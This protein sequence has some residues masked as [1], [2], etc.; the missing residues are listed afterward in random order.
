M[1]KNNQNQS[2]N[3]SEDKRRG[4]GRY[5]KAAIVCYRCNQ[6]GH[7]KQFCPGQKFIKD[8]SFILSQYL[9]K[10]IDTHC[11]LD[12]IF[13]KMRINSFDKL[14]KHFP[15]NFAGCISIYCDPAALSPSLS[16]YGEQLANDQVFGAFGIHPHNAKYYNESV[17]Q[18]ICEALTH[19]KAVA[20]GECGLDFHYNHSEKDIQLQVFEKQLI[21]AKELMKPIIIHAREA[22]TETYNLLKKTLPVD[23]RIHMHC[24]NDS[25][26]FAKKIL[27]EWPNMFIGI[28]GVITY[29]NAKQLKEVVTNILPLDRLLLETDAPY[30][31]PRPAQGVC[32]PGHIPNIA[33]AIAE[34]KQTSLEIVLDNARKNTTKM[35][36]I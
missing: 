32:H 15:D 19:P 27:L 18:R 20:W 6:V 23:H 13:Q 22:E 35:Y 21:K 33:S 4:R 28:T 16:T 29:N 26:E 11:H 25:P 30:M 12:Y 3:D 31:T 7:T 14:K 5:S 34:L 1:K 10:Y 24:F 17:E 2:N 9:P 8:E 36:G